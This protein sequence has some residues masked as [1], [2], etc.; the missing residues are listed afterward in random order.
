MDVP[1]LHQPAGIHHRHTIGHLGDHPDVVG[2]DDDGEVELVAEIAEQVEELRLDD[3]VQGGGRLVGDHQPG[4]ESQSQGDHHP[5]SHPPGELVRVVVEALVADTELLDELFGAGPGRQVGHLRLVGL[6]RLGEMLDHPLDGIQGGHRILKDHADAAA[7]HLP[8]LPLGDPHQIPALEPERAVGD[9]AGR[10]DHAHEGLAQC[11]LAASR[12]ADQ[13][14]DLPAPDV[15]RH[16][17]HG[18]DRTGAGV[19]HHREPPHGVG[20]LGHQRSLSLGLKISISPSPI[21]VNDSTTS[22]TAS[23]GKVI[24][25]QAV[26]M[27]S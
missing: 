12:L 21:M 18:V 26:W 16:V 23:P 13:A 22:I 9:L 24:S 14:Q 4:P 2:D 25:H 17:V 6:D 1:Q 3:H 20:D 8:H 11:R 10:G 27:L 5:L 19:V 15:E 7:A